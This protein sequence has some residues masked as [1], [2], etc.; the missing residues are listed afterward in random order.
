MTGTELIAKDL[1]ACLTQISSSPSSLEPEKPPLVQ[2][3]KNYLLQ[4]EENL[5]G[6]ADTNNFML[7]TINRC[8]DYTKASNG[9][10][11]VPK[12]ETISLNDCIRLPIQCMLNLQEKCTIVF[13]GFQETKICSHVITDK[14]WL[15]ENILCL[16]SNS[17]KYS[18]GGEIEIKIGLILDM[19]QVKKRSFTVFEEVIIPPQ[20]A[21]S[22]PSLSSKLQCVIEKTI[23]SSASTSRKKGL[24]YV[25]AE[26][27]ADD[28]H[29]LSSS[30]T[31][32]KSR[33]ISRN[34]HG[35]LLFEVSDRGIGISEEAMTKLFN[36]FKQAQ[37][38]AGGT[39]L[40]LYSLA[41]R[42]EAL[43]GFYGVHSQEDGCQGSVFWFALPYRPDQISSQRSTTGRKSSVVVSDSNKLVGSIRSRHSASCK[44]LSTPTSTS[45]P[46]SRPPSSYHILIA[47]DSLPIAKMITSMLKR[48]H[49]I[50]VVAE[51]GEIALNL[52]KASCSQFVN[53]NKNSENNN[54]SSSVI[55]TPFTSSSSLP[56]SSPCPPVVYDVVLMDFQM[57]VMDGLEATRRIRLLERELF[58]TQGIDRHQLIVGVSAN[59]DDDARQEAMQAGIDDFLPKPFTTDAFFQIM[60][61][62]RP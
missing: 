23:R 55:E 6:I 31:N 37:R 19:E 56:A 50:P 48:Q 27:A 24:V 43:K 44:T 61:K 10:K 16:L 49:H 28:P 8:L 18:N 26:G 45:I 38:L 12:F 33:S 7:M 11:L 62:F 46:S 40:G 53:N 13:N 5:Q 30:G 4:M 32:N 2:E 58:E 25:C 9:M 60:K 14:G 47:E 35:Y 17:V 34:G 20:P 59:S 52:W 3:I 36:P 41:K 1:S 22:S 54:N 15:Q 57:P 39:G 42:I 29:S 21:D 51:N